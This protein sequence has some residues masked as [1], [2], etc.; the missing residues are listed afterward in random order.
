M[1]ITEQIIERIA[2]RVFN[3]LF[4]SAL[5]NAGSWAVNISNV[6]HATKADH[7][8]EA[9]EVPW[10]G[11]QDVITDGNEFNLLDDVPTSGHLWINYQDRE[12][13]NLSSPVT[14]IKLGNGQGSGSG[15]TLVVDKISIGGIVIEWDSQKSALKINGSIYATGTVGSIG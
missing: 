3:A 9:D 5:K 15:V 10:T 7:A 1:K 8:N 11:V 12:G 6:Q 2:S 13:N 4:P 14:Q